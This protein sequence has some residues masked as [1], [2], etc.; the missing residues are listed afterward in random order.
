MKKRYLPVVFADIFLTFI[1]VLFAGM[2]RYGVPQFNY[3]Y[4]SLVLPFMLAAMILRPVIF[5]VAGVY[6]RIWRYSTTPD[7]LVLVGAVMGGTVVLLA[8][9]HFVFIPIWEQS[10]TPP[11]VLIEGLFN[12][13]LV[14]LFRFLIK[15]TEH[16]EGDI[17]WK[18]AGINPRR[19]V[20]I[21]GAGDAGV[22]TFM[23]I[24]E[25]PHLGMRAAAFIDDDPAKIG[26]KTQGLH[27]FGPIIGIAEVVRKRRI[28]EVII[29]I[30]NA[31]QQTI[32]NIQAM[33]RE[34][35]VPFRA[36]P[37]FGQF[38]DGGE[39]PVG[40]PSS[41][42]KIPMSM[43]DITAEEIQ[44]VVRVMQSRNLSIGSR[45]IEF[46][47]LIADVAQAKHAVAVTSG[48]SALHLCMVA[49]GIG[50][51]DEVITTPFSFIASANCILFEKG[52][53]VFVDIDPVTLNMDPA[54]V[55]A[56]ITERTKAI[57]VVHVFGQPA[58]MDPIMAIAAK[59]NIIVIEDACE[60]IGA[61]Y[62]GRRVGAIGRA[63]TFAF[64]PNKQM[65]TG[66][67]AALVTN[68]EEWA[69]LFRSLRN[70]GRDKFDGWLNHSRLGYNYRMSELNAAVGVVQLKRLDELLRKRNE[71]AGAYSKA[72]SSIEQLSP[73]EIAPTT[74]RMSW[75]VYVV[76][77]QE[78]IARDEVITRMEKRGI[79]AR[80]YF[81]PIHLQPFYRQRFGFEPGAFPEAERAG[82][83][84]IALPFH[85]NM[86]VEEIDV[87]C[88]ALKDVIAQMGKT[89]K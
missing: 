59:H 70:Q 75:F 45:T 72:L 35:P 65:T 49:S 26:R 58:D 18:K 56:A 37:Y 21:V 13:A 6:R 46:E 60:A 36:V 74:T 44:A 42:L 68:D 81:S 38:L 28:E 8:V 69:N 78:G 54:K 16:Y 40:I 23:E 71:V 87:V 32:M 9:S 55:E 25:N 63:G 4:L 31:P 62:K 30:P 10:F 64:Y 19:N 12:L 48:T 14:V 41:P 17:N 33:C 86:K 20:L 76:R 5:A 84:I 47:D 66:E 27:V 7:F 39:G 85:N 61:D 77:L 34:I 89:A 80:P 79:P 51:G 2:L 83:S 43:P 22:H 57:I 1:S 53:P 15:E 3:Q 24:E 50:P 82:E 52:T 29:A 88:R 67:G 73:L 11:A